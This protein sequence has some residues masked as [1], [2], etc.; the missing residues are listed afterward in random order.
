MIWNVLSKRS[1][2]KYDCLSTL[3][4]PVYQT[5]LSKLLWQRINIGVWGLGSVHLCISWETKVSADAFP[6]FQV[7]DW[8]RGEEIINRKKNETK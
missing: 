5:Y 3:Y 2:D 4:N 7:G 6:L 8:G 1:R